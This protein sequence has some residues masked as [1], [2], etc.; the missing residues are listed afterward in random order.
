MNI[1]LDRAHGSNVAGKQSPEG[2]KEWEWSQMVIDLLIP[3]LQKEGHTVY[4]IVSEPTEPG[5]N[6]RVKRMNNIP[7]PALVLSLHNNAAGMGNNWMNARGWSLWTSKGQ[8][9]SDELATELYCLLRQEFHELPY[10]TDFSDGDP[11]YDAHFTVLTSKHPSVMIEW[12][13]QDNRQDSEIIWDNKFNIRLCKT[14]V[15]WISS[16]K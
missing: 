12:M 16:I 14:I 1:A 8:T 7:S 11:D 4:N 10:R 13:F 15:S 3:M 6:E 2:R 9:R 5:L